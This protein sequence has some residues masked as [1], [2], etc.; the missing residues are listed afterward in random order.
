MVTR[1]IWKHSVQKA[2]FS[3]QTLGHWLWQVFPEGFQGSQ[4]N[5]AESAGEAVPLQQ[6]KSG[7]ALKV[8]SPD[9][10]EYIC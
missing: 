7:G 4:S 5:T 10:Q 8:S 1:D 9:F 3:R 2:S 6:V